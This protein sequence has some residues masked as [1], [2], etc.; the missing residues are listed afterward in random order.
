[1]LKSLNILPESEPF[2]PL[3]GGA[4]A[5]WV[6]NVYRHI[7]QIATTVICPPDRN[8]YD[9]FNVCHISNND[10]PL[11]IYNI[12]SPLCCIRLPGRMKSYLANGYLR[13]TAAFVQKNNQFD[14]IHIHN[15]PEYI[16][17]IRQANSNAQL[18]LHLQNDHLLNYNKQQR[19]TLLE[20][21]DHVLFCSQYIMKQALCD[22][23]ITLSNKCSVIHNGV[24]C[25]NFK[26]GIPYPTGLLRPQERYICFIGRLVPEKGIHILLDA[27]A[28]VFA[29]VSDCKLLIVGGAHFGNNEETF[30]IAQLKRTSHLFQDKIIFTGAVS[31][32]E[33]AGIYANAVAFVCPSTWDEPFGM[34]NVEALACGTPVIASKRG[35]IPEA[36][37]E[38][39]ILFDPEDSNSLVE[40][41]IKVLSD[42]SYAKLLGQKGRERAIKKFD[43][44]IIANQYKDVVTTIVQ[45]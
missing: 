9:G 28:M 15:R 40:A 25:T 43:W 29:R 44:K 2:S 30:Y 23:P 13:R 8:E 5:I 18:V 26:P 16:P 24:D 27:M 42:S 20:L 37:G 33:L 19:T 32:L 11:T 35:G 10:V 39:G 36:I 34:V 4:L 41:L 38:A 21:S 17:A 7:D 12:L 14:V 45:A 3:R 1:M 31:H 22:L 6:S